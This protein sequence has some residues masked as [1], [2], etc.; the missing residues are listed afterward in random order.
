[1]ERPLDCKV[2][3]AYDV[4]LVR[5]LAVAATVLTVQW[6]MVAGAWAHGS[7]GGVSLS[8]IP[9]LPLPCFLQV[10]PQLASS[11]HTLSHIRW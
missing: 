6:C 8:S 3:A 10:T 5:R 9:G 11:L 2:I 4:V 7:L 1:M